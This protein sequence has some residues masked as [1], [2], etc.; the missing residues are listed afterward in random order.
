MISCCYS[1]WFVLLGPALIEDLISRPVLVVG[2]SSLHGRDL[3]R[4]KMIV[5][6][7]VLQ[8]HGYGRRLAFLIISDDFILIIAFDSLFHVI[9]IVDFTVIVI[10]VIAFIAW[11]DF[12]EGTPGNELLPLVLGEQVGKGQ[13]EVTSR[14]HD[15]DDIKLCIKDL[16]CFVD[17]SPPARLSAAQKTAR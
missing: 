17:T 6:E 15:I 3:P 4:L 16:A 5:L 9:E 7:I 2:K 8:G 1:F 14:L 10:T 12:S 11:V 13:V